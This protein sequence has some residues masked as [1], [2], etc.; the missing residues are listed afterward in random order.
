MHNPPIFTIPQIITKWNLK[1]PSLRAQNDYKI[2]VSLLEVR[3]S[4][5]LSNPSERDY[6]NNVVFSVTILFALLNA[7][8]KLHVYS[9]QH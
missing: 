5:F 2:E 7:N 1:S 3:I 9:H 6:T 8:C 4:A